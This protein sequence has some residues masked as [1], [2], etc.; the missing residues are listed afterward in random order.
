MLL[1]PRCE[2]ML[3]NH[4]QCPN[5]QEAGSDNCSLHN[6]LSNRLAD[7]DETIQS[8]ATHQNESL[9]ISDDEIN[10]TGLVF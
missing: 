2:V 4:T 1:G 3:P 10:K 5:V 7:V 6:Q 8:T 9:P